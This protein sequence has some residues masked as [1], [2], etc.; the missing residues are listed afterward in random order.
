MFQ[1][2]MHFSKDSSLEVASRI[3]N[4]EEKVMLTITGRKNEQELTSSS[5]ILS[6]EHLK[7]LISSLQEAVDREKNWPPKQ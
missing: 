3:F 7:S 5:I 2:I 1:R 4:N 6:D